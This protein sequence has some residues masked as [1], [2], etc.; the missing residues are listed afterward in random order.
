MSEVN[1]CSYGKLAPFEPY[2]NPRSSVKPAVLA[3]GAGKDN[4]TDSYGFIEKAIIGS[5]VVT[6]STAALKA[7]GTYQSNQKINHLMDAVVNRTVDRLRNSIQTGFNVNNY[8]DL[9]DRQEFVKG[10]VQTMVDEPEGQTAL[11]NILYAPE[12][13][14]ANFLDIGPGNSAETFI[15]R[16]AGDR[17][18]TFSNRAASQNELRGSRLQELLIEGDYA[19]LEEIAA[20]DH[21]TPRDPVLAQ[22][23]ASEIMVAYSGDEIFTDEELQQLSTTQREEVHHRVREQYPTIQ[24][25]NELRLD[26]FLRI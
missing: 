1:I 25:L 10:S 16:F 21:L 22:T 3:A 5:I 26:Q 6:V 14:R 4:Q 11:Q 7:Y 8:P 17:S 13:S 20:A 23:L 18:V 19:N 2:L 24:V 12:Y 9:F 15:A